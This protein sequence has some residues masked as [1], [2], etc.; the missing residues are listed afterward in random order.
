MI[1]Q[2]ARNLLN[3]SV[4]QSLNSAANYIIS[5]STTNALPPSSAQSVVTYKSFTDFQAALQSHSVPQGTQWILLDL[6][7]WQ[8]T[9][10]AEQKDPLKYY[11]MA[12]DYAKRYGYGLIAAP[13]LSL[14]PGSFDQKLS[15]IER[16]NFYGKVSK[17]ASI[18]EIQSQSLEFNNSNFSRL[19]DTALTQAKTTDQ[20]TS[21]FAGLSTNPPAGVATA[22]QLLNLVNS[23]PIG[24]QGFWMNIPSPGAMCPNCNVQ[25]PDVADAMFQALGM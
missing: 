10:L 6:E 9:P 19:V 16:S 18:V 1:S 24:L 21:V 4:Q 13:G 22:S 17:Y 11:S 20:L 15:Y 7:K 23:A 25:S 14:F 8:F 12:S 5:P 2:S 3:T